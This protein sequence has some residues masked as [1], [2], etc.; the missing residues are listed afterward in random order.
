MGA[1]APMPA[2]SSPGRGRRSSAPHPSARWRSRA[3]RRERPSGSRPLSSGRR[4]WKSR[5]GWSLAPRAAPVPAPHPPGSLDLRECALRR[6]RGQ[7]RGG[8]PRAGRSASRG[9]QPGRPPRA[10]RPNLSPSHRQHMRLSGGS[11][12]IW[13]GAPTDKI[14]LTW[15]RNHSNVVTPASRGDGARADAARC[16]VRVKAWNARWQA[17]GGG[18]G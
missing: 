15:S 13:T 8:A 5:F 6:A 16:G 11:R 3:R 14:H 2:S 4:S 18:N 7:P 10:T 12:L 17:S 9:Q 1:R